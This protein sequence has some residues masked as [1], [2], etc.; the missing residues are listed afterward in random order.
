MNPL[1]LIRFSLNITQGATLQLVEGLSKAPLQPA[2]PGG[3]A[4]DGNH[5]IWLFGHLAYV[6]SLILNSVL[7]GKPDPL[8]KWELI[9]K[10]G[11][12]STTDASMYPTLDEVVEA[13]KTNR[14]AT[15]AHIDRLDAATLDDKPKMIPPGFEPLM[16][17]VGNTLMVIAIHNMDHHGQIADVRR[18]IGL[19]KFS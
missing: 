5:A 6:E 17:S 1:D 10:Q 13:Y 11:S 14:A 16:S 7:Q 12:T 2:T 15:L 18:T 3:K 4:G 19:K 9:F 8:P